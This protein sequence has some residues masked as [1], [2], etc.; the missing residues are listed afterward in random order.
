MSTSLPVTRATPT[1]S[2]PAFGRAYRR[3][4]GQHVQDRIALAQ[5]RRRQIL[6]FLLSLHPAVA[7]HDHD[8]V[9]LD[10]EVVWPVFLL[11]GIAFDRRTT[12][13][14]VLLVRLF[15]LA[16]HQ[17]PA[18]VLVLEQRGDLPRALPLLFELV[19]DE[20]N[21]EPGEPVDL[22]LENRVGLVHVQLEPLHDFFRGVG[23]AVRLADDLD[24][25]VERVEDR[26]ETFEDVDALLERGELVLEPFRDHLETEMEEVPED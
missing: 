16:A 22:E 6:H 20:Q 9:F 18:A 25:L 5:P 17:L 3:A 26:L 7:R 8:V 12:L 14:A 4:A 11:A 13:V 19:A 24:D 1:T 23:L 15:D 21:L 2:A 10:D